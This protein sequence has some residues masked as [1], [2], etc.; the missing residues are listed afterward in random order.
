MRNG[1]RVNSST[2]APS[3]NE[4]EP[5]RARCRASAADHRSASQ[6]RPKRQARRG[7]SPHFAGVRPTSTTQRERTPA[8]TSRG[9]ITNPTQRIQPVCMKIRCVARRRAAGTTTLAS[10]G[11]CR[12]DPEQQRDV[13]GLAEAERRHDV[14]LDGGQPRML[15]NRVDVVPDRRAERERDGNAEDGARDERSPHAA[16]LAVVSNRFPSPSGPRR[17]EWMKVRA[18]S[19]DSRYFDVQEAD[20]R[21]EPEHDL[22]G[23][24]LPEH[25]RVL[26]TRHRD[27]PDPRR[28]VHARVPLLLRPL[29]QA[30]V[31][32]RPARA[33]AARA[34]RGAD[35]AQARRRHVG[36]PRRRPRPGAG[37]YAATIRA[38]KASCRRRR[39]RC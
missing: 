14:R 3:G 34:G 29:G 8:S 6:S 17:P 38:L 39:S 28:H 1:V 4:P 22:R 16:I 31:A 12:A 24:A 26:G 27:V 37:H 15:A 35:A 7:R 30:G 10:S 20:P 36:R 2:P 33:A 21:R 9:A 11:T 18:P 5:A 25:R 19:P 32:A 13:A 23:G